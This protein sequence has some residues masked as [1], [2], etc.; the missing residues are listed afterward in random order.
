MLDNNKKFPLRYRFDSEDLQSS[1]WT[2]Y[3]L[4]ARPDIWYNGYDG[5][6][7]GLNMNG[8]YMNYKHIFD[9]TIWFNTGIGQN[10]L[11]STVAKD[12]YDNISFRVSYRTATDKFMKG[13]SFNVSAKAL[14]GLNAYTVGFDRKDIKGKN[15][16]YMF[17][18]SMYCKGLNDITYLLMPTEW[19]PNKLNNTINVGLEH[20]YSY[21]RGTGNINIG[22]KSTAL[23]SDYDYQSINLNIINR[24]R[25]GRLVLNTR[26]VGQ[27][28]T[29]KIGQM[30]LLYFWLE[31]IQKK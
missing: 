14:D 22:L 20:T 17:F 26:L 2:R 23:M 9:A 31:Q 7:A 11:D 13:S 15:R 19:A 6:K 10:Y 24:T 27:Y 3:E 25:L 18:K 21:R 5:L 4:Y 1:D 29:G 12:L 8:N 30:N 28:G 16:V